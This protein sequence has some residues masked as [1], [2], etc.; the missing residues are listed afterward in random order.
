[1]FNLHDI[2]RNAIV[3]NHPDESVWR[4]RSLGQKNVAGK[5]VPE[6]GDP[7]QLDAQIQSES[8]ESLYHADRAGENDIT[9]NFYVYSP[10]NPGERV[11]G[12]FRPLARSGDMIYRNSENTWWLVTALVEDF[13]DVG[14]CKVRCT[15]QVNAPEGVFDVPA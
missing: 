15:M 8:D 3:T 12:I 13:S 1:M 5:Y 14:W 9:K 10:F 6:Y 7:E 11:S 2:V 4:Y